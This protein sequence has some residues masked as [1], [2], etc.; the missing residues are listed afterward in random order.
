M[1]KYICPTGLKKLEKGNI[2]YKTTGNARKIELDLYY[3]NTN[4]KSISY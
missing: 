3:L 4:V 2:S 1:K